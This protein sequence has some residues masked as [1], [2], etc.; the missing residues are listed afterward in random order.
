MYFRQKKEEKEEE[1]EEEINTVSYCYATDLSTRSAKRL[2]LSMGLYMYI[3]PHFMIPIP[4][5]EGLSTD[6]L[7]CKWILT[8]ANKNKCTCTL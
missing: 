2:W 8:M 6:L 4:V 1:E 3:C 5:L 7:Q